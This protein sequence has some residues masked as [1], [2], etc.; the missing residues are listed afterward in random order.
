[1]VYK[2]KKKK[3]FVNITFTCLVIWDM[4]KNASHKVEEVEEYLK[5]YI[6]VYF[7]H[8]HL[9]I[10]NDHTLSYIYVLL[11][12]SQTLSVIHFIRCFKSRSII[13]I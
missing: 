12:V 7:F 9:S 6:F 10:D 1:M 5:V 8:F 2:L 4:E 11:E 13:Y 3:L